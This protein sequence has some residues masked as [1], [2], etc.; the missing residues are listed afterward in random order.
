MGD[1]LIA[2]GGVAFSPDGAL[3]ATGGPDSTVQLWDVAA[4]RLLGGPLTGHSN[5][6]TSVAFSPNGKLLLSASAES[7]RPWDIDPNSWA[8]QLCT[9][10]N[11]NLSLAEWQQFIGP[12]VPY[13]RTCANLPPGE[14]VP[15]K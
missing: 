10:A 3:L 6:V 11:R 4:R 9:I 2:E 8:A 5:R 12:G 15:G 14:G 13:Q 7:V 1:P